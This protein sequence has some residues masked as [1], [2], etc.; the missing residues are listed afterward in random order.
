LKFPIEQAFYIAYLTV[1][2][3][4]ESTLEALAQKLDLGTNTVWAFKTKVNTR[5]SE[6]EKRHKKP[7]LSRWHEIILEVPKVSHHEPQQL[8]SI[9]KTI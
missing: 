5:I 4:K 7:Q 8:Q 3:K 2:G 6:L 9:D 1:T